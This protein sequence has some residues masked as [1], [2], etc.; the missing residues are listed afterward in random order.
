[1]KSMKR[2]KQRDEKQN[3]LNSNRTS[4]PSNGRIRTVYEK[5]GSESKDDNDRQISLQNK[6]DSFHYENSMH[7]SQIE[8]MRQL[9]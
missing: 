1:M 2:V 8:M 3:R 5:P 9:E 6:E 7:G 4:D